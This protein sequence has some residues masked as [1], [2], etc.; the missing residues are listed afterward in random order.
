MLKVFRSERGY[1]L[2]RSMEAL[3]RVVQRVDSSSK[4]AEFQKMSTVMEKK[5]RDF[6]DEAF[7]G[8]ERSGDQESQTTS[9]KF[10]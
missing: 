10:H 3:V 4:R 7:L 9:D 8:L 1:N 5:W 6:A 2:L